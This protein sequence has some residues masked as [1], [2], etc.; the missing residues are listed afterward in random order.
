MHDKIEQGA[1]DELPD[2]GPVQVRVIPGGG[3]YIGPISLKGV[4]APETVRLPEGTFWQWILDGGGPAAVAFVQG[5]RT[6]APVETLGAAGFSALHVH[7][8]TDIYL[9]FTGPAGAFVWIFVSSE[10][11]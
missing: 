10:V 9:A 8:G 11:R 7:P 5:S 4:A 6:T 1:P 2:D 3:S